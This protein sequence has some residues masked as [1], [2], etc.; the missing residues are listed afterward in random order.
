MF[1]N[2]FYHFLFIIDRDKNC[3]GIYKF[4]TQNYNGFYLLI[5]YNFYN[6]N[7]LCV[8]RY[9]DSWYVKRKTSFFLIVM[10]I[11]NY[12]ILLIKNKNIKYKKAKYRE[13]NH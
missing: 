13:K 6:I 11:T 7:I 12:S 5:R 10:K 3:R 8:C 4:D 9:L 2:K 1:R